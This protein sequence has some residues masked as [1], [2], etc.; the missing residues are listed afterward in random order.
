MPE[1]HKRS[2]N[3]LVLKKQRHYYTKPVK[4]YRMHHANLILHGYRRSLTYGGNECG[5]KGILGKSEQ[6]TGLANA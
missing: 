6:H 1:N 2:V 3:C 4:F 5:I